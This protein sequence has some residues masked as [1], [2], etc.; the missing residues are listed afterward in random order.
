MLTKDLIRCRLEKGV[1]RPRFI[2]TRDE[3]LRRVA[4]RLLAAYRTQP[5]PTR[6]DVEE[7]VAGIISTCPDP[8]LARGLDKLLT[9]RCEFAIA[10][11]HDYPSLRAAVFRV[12]GEVL[13]RG[14]LESAESYRAAVLERAGVV[15]RL[16]EADLYADLPENERLVRFRD[17][18][19]QQLLERYNVGLVQALLLRAS[20]LEV[21][22]SSPEPAKMR[23][24]LKYVRFFRLLARISPVADESGDVPGVAPALRL[25]IDGPASVLA[26]SKRYGLQ[27]ACFFP[28]LCALDAWSLDT[29]VD[30]KGHPRRLCLSQASGLVSPYRNFSAYVPEEIRL[31]HD[32]FRRTVADW[33]I[34]GETPFLH[35]GAQEMVFPDLSFSRADGTVCHLELFHRWHA[36]PLLDRLRL[37]GDRPALPLIIGVDQALVRDPAVEAALAGSAWFQGRGFV[38]RDYP[39]VEKTLACLERATA[40]VRG[41]EGTH[42]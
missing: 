18:G 5:P 28:A 40:G 32:Y 42:P 25:R 20:G 16:G 24:V 12:A 19:P 41:R 6:G 4:E 15:A 8:L 35:G 23:R 9:D 17:L 11:A 33:R 39:T 36:G 27:L 21:T 31:F 34:T 2:D 29:Q 37:V 1:V 30:W 13:R 22:V 14:R 10:A 26:E 3:A 38:F 7:G